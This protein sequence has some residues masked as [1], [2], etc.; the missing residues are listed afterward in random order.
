MKKNPQQNQQKSLQKDAVNK[1]KPSLNFRINGGK[2]L[3]GNIKVRTSKK[4]C[5]RYNVRISFK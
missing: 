4:W 2:T 3:K 5:S 1:A